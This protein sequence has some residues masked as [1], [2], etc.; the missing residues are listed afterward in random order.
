MTD[1][2]HTRGLRWTVAGWTVIVIAALLAAS[3]LIGDYLL[4]D[5]SLEEVPLAFAF[6][7]FAVVGAVLM[8]RVP[9]HR[10]GPLF[11]FIGLTPMLGAA[12]ELLGA[13]IAA[14]GAPGALTAMVGELF[15][16]P[17]IALALV[18]PAL[19]FPTGHAPSPR[20]AW[21]GW[22]TVVLAVSFMV[23]TVFQP[24]FITFDASGQMRTV[25]N[26]IG[27]QGL[28][29]EEREIVFFVALALLSVFSLASLVVRYRRADAELRAQLK[30][31]LYAVALL[32]AWLVAL[33]FVPSLAESEW[34]RVL[35]VLALL[36]AGI[37]VS[38]AIAILRYR[39]YDIDVVINKTLVYG[40]LAVFV[41]LVYVA[42]VVGIG[43][44]VG[45]TGNLILSIVATAVVAVAFQPMREW[46]Q[47]FANRV[48]YGQRAT[49]YEVLS[50][51]SGRMAH[52]QATEEL[53][54]RIAAMVAEG[55]GAARVEVWLRVG[56]DL[57]R[58]GVWSDQAS[59]PLAIAHHGGRHSFGSRRRRRRP[60]QPPGRTPRCDQR[61]QAPQRS[62]QFGGGEAAG[63]SR[64]AGWAGAA[65][66]PAGRGAAELATEAGDGAGRR[67]SSSGTEPP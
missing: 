10:L 45:G 8:L 29:N 60:S 32:V 7:S 43:T 26:P 39:L 42:L 55:I 59:P 46:V 47:R 14:P 3:L 25:H 34:S 31:L 52:T 49:P 36:L 35:M 61:G 24:W 2:V 53:L 12:V 4:D 38:A 30:W 50:D 66:R 13:Q 27:I 64:L 54:P 11:A 1:A 17:T 33:V 65:Q 9:G 57:V 16:T 51:L 5:L 48:V 62:S 44:L 56:P 6:F 22:A 40:V 67:T 58:E 21:V 41:T 19:L 20:W 37:P 28:P 23:F 18:L 15:L 63:G